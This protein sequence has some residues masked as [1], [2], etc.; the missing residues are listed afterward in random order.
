M[1]KKTDITSMID[2]NPRA[3][4]D[5][6]TL[7]K[8]LEAVKQLRDMGRKSKG[9]DLASPFERRRSKEARRIVVAHS[10]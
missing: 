10:N 1:N 7:E 2:K 5:K 3:A 8:A 4:R 9:Y 6:E